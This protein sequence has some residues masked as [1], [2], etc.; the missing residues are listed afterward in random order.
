VFEH[1]TGLLDAQKMDRLLLKLANGSISNEEV[2]NDSGHGA[3]AGEAERLNL[4]AEDFGVIVTGPRRNLMYKS[5]LRPYFA[6]PFGDMMLSGCFG[7]LASTAELLP[8]LS[9]RIWASLTGRGGTGAPP[10]EAD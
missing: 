7:L 6:T 3:F 9:E 1:H 10:W 8:D 2:Y 4:E 5:A